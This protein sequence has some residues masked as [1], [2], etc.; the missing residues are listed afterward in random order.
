LSFFPNTPLTL[1]YTY[2]FVCLVK[3]TQ[4]PNQTIEEIMK[5][6]IVLAFCAVAT[7]SL[8]SCG[9]H[10]LTASEKDQTELGAR[11]YA[12]RAGNTFIACSGQDSDGDGYVTCNTKTKAGAPEDIVCSYATRGCKRKG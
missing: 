8:A 3:P 1:K 9:E 5:K 2:V 7:L 10:V 11:D 6:L 12:E 4:H